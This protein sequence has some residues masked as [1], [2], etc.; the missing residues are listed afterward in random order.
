MYSYKPHYACFNCRKTFKRKLLV[1]VDRDAAYNKEK[2]S[3]TCP[4]CGSLTMDM[5]LDFE[6]PKKT[7]LKAWKHIENLYQAGITFHSCGCTGP[8]YIPKD[9][10]QLMNLLLKRKEQYID[11]LRFWKNRIEPQTQSE[12]QT[13][14]KQHQDYLFTLPEDVKSGPQKNRKIETDKAVIYWTEK[15]SDIESKIEEFSY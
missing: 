12:K 4:E 2:K 10:E 13:D 8:G 3:A 9:K 5:G 11:H 7:D 6:S 1:D 15:V 14:W